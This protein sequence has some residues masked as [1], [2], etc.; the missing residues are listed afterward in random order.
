MTTPNYDK[1]DGAQVMNK[2]PW[3]E[4]LGVHIIV[5]ERWIGRD[6]RTKGFC[7]FA[8]WTVVKTLAGNDAAVGA[9]RSRMRKW[10]SDGTDSEMKNRAQAG[11]SAAGQKNKPGFEFPITAVTGQIVK[12][13]HDDAGKKIVGYPL[14]IEVSTVKMK[15]GDPFTAIVEADKWFRENV[16]AKPG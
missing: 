15:N 14:K 13:M 10:S 3:H 1:I 2:Y 4:E 6:T 12:G 7:D 9:K 5:V 8:D 11:L 16:E